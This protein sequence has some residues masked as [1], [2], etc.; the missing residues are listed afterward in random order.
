LFQDF[1]YQYDR[2]APFFSHNYLD[3]ACWA[4][5]ASAVD[6]PDARRAALVSALR[7]QN[8]PSA[9][10]DLLAKPGT[11]VVVTGQQ[12]GL[13]GGP[14]YTI[15]KA[16]TA[17]RLAADLTASGINAVPVFWLATED[18]DFE[19]VNHA[20]TFDQH[21][22]PRKLQ[23]KVAGQE[24]RPVGGV[25]VDQ[26]PIEDLKQ[27]LAGMPFGA[28]V[29]ALVEESYA[30]GSTMGAAFSSLLRKLLPDLGLLYL[31]PMDAAVRAI[32]SPIVRDAVLASGDLKRLLMERDSVLEKAGYHAQVHVE[33]STSLFFLLE[34]GRRTTLRYGDDRYAGLTGKWTS[35][36]LAERAEQ[37]SPNALFRPVVQDYLLP[38]IAQ[39]GGPAEVAYLAQSQV[40]YQALGRVAPVA[41]PRSGFTLFDARGGKLMS[42]YGLN[43]TDFFEGPAPLKERISRTLVPQDLQAS[44]AETREAAGALMSRLESSLAGFDKTLASSTSKSR[45]KILYQMSKI[46]AKAARQALA[47]DTRAGTD[48][49]YLFNLVYPHKHLQ[50]RLYG[51]LPFLAMNGLGLIKEIGEHVRLECPDHVVLTV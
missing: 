6:F 7:A 5:A 8:G 28:E 24:Q 36:E 10:L 15:Y 33:K 29:A 3:P 43:P 44:L 35:S 14:C 48:A 21:L 34:D 17:A 51:V 50:E 20:W 2:V 19:E 11:V 9:S 30:P 12:V 27:S 39:V 13:F 25:V 16:L 23:V 26:F 1:L 49:D 46:E 22:L 31:D 45:A 40:L 41:V 4:K 38:T 37:L 47:R 32:A 18:H 42:R